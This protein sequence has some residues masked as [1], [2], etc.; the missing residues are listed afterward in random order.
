VLVLS[1]NTS[2]AVTPCIRFAGSAPGPLAIPTG[3]PWAG[4]K[5][6][7]T[8]CGLI[9]VFLLFVGV[10]LGVSLVV[11][12]LCDLMEKIWIFYLSA[13][14]PGASLPHD[15]QCGALSVMGEDC[16]GFWAVFLRLS[17]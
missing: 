9:V 15:V 8:I 11:L 4:F 3:S 5:Y 2:G 16:P 6:C 12:P 1:K 10:P 14:G 13:E 7:C 17:W